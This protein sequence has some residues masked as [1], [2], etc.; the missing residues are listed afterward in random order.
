MDLMLLIFLLGFLVAN[1]V[2]Y[3]LYRRASK[4]TKVSVIFYMLSLVDR[5]QLL[6]EEERRGVSKRVF[7][8]GCAVLLTS[9][10]LI[11]SG[12]QPV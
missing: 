1:V 7:A 9:L 6:T 2:V 10:I 12:W 5:K 4:R 3:P 8:V 11:A